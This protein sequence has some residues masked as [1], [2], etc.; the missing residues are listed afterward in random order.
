V[1]YNDRF[2]IRYNGQMDGALAVTGQDIIRWQAGS[3][4]LFNLTR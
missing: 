1:R 3:G 2:Q 4:Q